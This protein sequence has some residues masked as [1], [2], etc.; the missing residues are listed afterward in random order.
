[1]YIDLYM[2]KECTTSYASQADN[3]T[4]NLRV[5]SLHV[6]DLHVHMYVCVYLNKYIYTYTYICAYIY[7]HICI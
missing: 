5:V 7:I 6:Y 4:R 3:D 2:Y 1:M